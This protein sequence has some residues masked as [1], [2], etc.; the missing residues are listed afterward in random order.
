MWDW[1]GSRITRAAR[2]AAADR[3]EGTT[4]ATN[5][6]AVVVA[7]AALAACGYLLA[8]TVGRMRRK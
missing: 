7:L 4:V 1:L 2:T 5:V 6:L 8:A 3:D